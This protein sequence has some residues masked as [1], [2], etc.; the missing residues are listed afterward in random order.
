MKRARTYL[1][2]DLKSFYASVECV[3]KGLDPL[4]A[5]LVVADPARGPKTICLA[6]SP[7]LKH[8]GVRNRCRVF[9]IPL[10]ISYEKAVPRMRLYME[11]SARIY[12]IYLEHIS[13]QDIHIYSV[14]ECFIDATSYLRLYQMT[15]RQFASKLMGEIR[16]RTGIPAAAGIGSNLFLAK[17]ALD[18]TAKHAG[19]GIGVLTE[20]TFRQQIWPHRPITDIW[21]I[22]AGTARR[23]AAYHVHDLMGVAA[24]DESILYRELGVRAEYLIDHA[25]GREPVTIA[26]I[27]AYRPA[28]SSLVSGQVLHRDYT[29]EEARTALR[30]MVD[31][32]VLELVGRHV[33]AGGISLF[34]GYGKNVPPARNA[35]ATCV[36]PSAHSALDDTALLERQNPDGSIGGGVRA[37]SR[38]A[39]DTFPGE[40]AGRIARGAWGHAGGQRK[41]SGHTNSFRKIWETFEWLFDETVDPARAIKRMSIGFGDLLP[42]E[43]ADVDLFTDQ[44][45]EGAERQLA[46]TVNAVKGR[47]GKNALL[48]GTSF[49]RGATGRERN[50]QVGGHR[51]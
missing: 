8:L 13:P 3:D 34:V 48:R 36:D 19:D 11:V 18:I 2:I 42:E 23:L 50:E 31:T 43:F 22:G 15:A 35:P 28:A 40:F 9:E 51:A 20:E 46:L 39:G 32:S 4:T 21:G 1:C 49:K 30:E 12:G 38:L 27:Q 33:V 14:D 44:A 47:W 45:A 29:R 16:S 37:M 17:V 25:H 6:V 7:A 24:L 5:R 41:L 26:E 10:G